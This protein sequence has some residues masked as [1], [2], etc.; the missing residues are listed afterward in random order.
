MRANFFDTAS[1]GSSWGSVGDVGELNC[2]KVSCDR[3][4]ASMPSS[5]HWLRRVVTTLWWRAARCQKQLRK[6]TDILGID[7][8]W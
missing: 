8:V 7:T 5:V 6:R 4:Q 2:L 3:A 1:L